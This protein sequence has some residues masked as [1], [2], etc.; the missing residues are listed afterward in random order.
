M[1]DFIVNV[2]VAYYLVAL[3]VG[4]WLDRRENRNRSP[5]SWHWSKWQWR[6]LG[7]PM[8]LAIFAM[9]GV[10]VVMFAWGIFTFRHWW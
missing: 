6:L 4:V 10:G 3:L 9:F 2:F 8:S 5:R 7:L 1:K